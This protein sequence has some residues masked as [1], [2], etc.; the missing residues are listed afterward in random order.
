MISLKRSVIFAALAVTLVGAACSGTDVTALATVN[1]TQIDLDDMRDLRASYGEDFVET[2]TEQFRV[3]LGRLIFLQALLEAATDPGLG[4]TISDAD[5]QERIANPPPRYAAG[6][7][8]IAADPDL[9]DGALRLQATFSLIED[10]VTTRLLQEDEGYLAGILQD[11]PEQIASACVRHILVDT[12]FDAESIISE[13]AAGADFAELAAEFSIDTANAGSGGLLAESPE[14]CLLPL[15]NWTPA[16]GHAAA[17][18]EIGA[19][20]GP[21]QT[22]FG[23]HVIRVDERSSLPTL[24]DLTADPLA[25]VGTIEI[26][27]VF[28]PWW[29]DEVRNA[30]IT[31]NPL[32]GS[33]F[34]EGLGIVPPDA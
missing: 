25:Y 24:E 21:V 22:D 9:G 2:N 6:F 10:R 4:I 33:W 27:R 18:G 32:V 20:L 28:T 3:D 7:A 31:V 29:N 23:F 14:T 26:S 13:L 17:T 5:V 8:G 34:A 30:E 1:G 19:I 16:F 11:Q 15:S 12:I